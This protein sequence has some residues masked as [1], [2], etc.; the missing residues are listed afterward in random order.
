MEDESVE[1]FILIIY[2]RDLRPCA[3]I[4]Y[5]CDSSDVFS[6]RV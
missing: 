1:P 5:L 4:D 2:V 6:P 3:K